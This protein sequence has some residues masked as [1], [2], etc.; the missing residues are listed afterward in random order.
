MKKILKTFSIAACAFLALAACN[1]IQNGELSA[2]EKEIKSAVESYVPDVVYATYGELAAA[3]KTLYEDIDA[4]KEKGVA[5]VSQADIDKACTDFLAARALWEASEAFLFGAATDFSIDPHIDSWPLDASRLA[6]NLSN[7]A[8]VEKLAEEGMGAI[9]L[10]GESALGFH[11]IE[12]ILFRDGKN[13][14]VAALRAE[15]TATEFKGT[16][17]TGEEE[18]IFAAAVA[19]DLMTSLYQLNVSWNP[20]APQEQKDAVEEAELNCTVNGTDLTYGENMLNAAAAGSTYATW[21]QVAQTILDAGCANIANEVFSSKMGMAFSGEDP[22]YI[23]SPYSKKSFVDFKDN[24]LSIQYSL[25]GAKGASEPKANSLMSFLQ[26][27]HKEDA[28]TLASKL[29]AALSALDA[30]IG[31]GKA[32]VDDPKAKCVETAIDAISELNDALGQAASDIK[33]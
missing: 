1:P 23:E 4:M 9:D 28:A 32:F 6:I 18:L 16:G 26:K 22:S 19:E 11:G 5:A 29:S 10:I 20:N 7:K 21:Q 15:E 25:Y 30:C 24:I 17:V 14:S 27:N 13:R 12:F 2:Y 31:S 8:A 3:G 33:D